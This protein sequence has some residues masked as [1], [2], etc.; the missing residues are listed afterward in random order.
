M[1]WGNPPKLIGTQSQ[2]SLWL[3]MDWEETVLA[4]L[5]QTEQQNRP[6]GK[7]S[8]SKG[9]AASDFWKKLFLLQGF[10]SQIWA[11]AGKKP[12]RFSFGE[13]TLLPALFFSLACFMLSFSFPCTPYLLSFQ[14]TSRVS[15]SILVLG[16]IHQLSDKLLVLFYKSVPPNKFPPSTFSISTACTLMSQKSTPEEKKNSCFLVLTRKLYTFHCSAGVHTAS[17]HE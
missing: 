2:P 4:E 15:F 12:F 16:F 10:R 8:Q 3:L 17:T 9:N 1:H 11:L 14:N 7:D 5:P 6:P 13:N